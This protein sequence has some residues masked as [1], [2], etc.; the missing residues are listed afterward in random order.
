MY[1]DIWR[2]RPYS[3]AVERQFR[4]ALEPYFASDTG[5]AAN[6]G[7]TGFQSLPVNVWETAEGYGATFLAPGLI[8][9]SI[10]VTFHDD[11]L[12]IEGERRY[13]VPEGAKAVWQEFGSARFRRSLRLGA[14]V[15]SARVQ[16]Q[17][18]NGLLTLRMPKME[19]TKPRQIQVQHGPGEAVLSA[20][21]TGGVST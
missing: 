14:G 10:N 18:D 11:T 1:T 7:T 4:E 6:G 16:A 13:D 3:T 9:E 17:S 2:T 12:A 21:K 8:A 19:N 15:D 5:S 20:A